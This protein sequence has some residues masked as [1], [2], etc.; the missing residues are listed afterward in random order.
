M[1]GESRLWADGGCGV[2]LTKWRV[3]KPQR[4]AFEAVR[5][6]DN[7]CFVFFCPHP[8]Y[9][10]M[11]D[12]QEIDAHLIIEGRPMLRNRYKGYPNV[13]VATVIPTGLSFLVEQFR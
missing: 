13:E 7:K 5:L 3:R 8:L 1:S 9:Q 12:K 2:I 6:F 10:L 11:L 4:K